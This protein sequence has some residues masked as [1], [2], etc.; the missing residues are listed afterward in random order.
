MTDTHM[1]SCVTNCPSGELSDATIDAAS[2]YIDGKCMAH[3]DSPPGLPC[4]KCDAIADQ[5][6]LPA[7]M[8]SDDTCFIGGYCVNAGLTRP[9]YHRYSSDS[10]CESCDPARN[11]ADWSITQGF[12][13]DQVFEKD[14][15]C[16]WTTASTG[17][18]RAHYA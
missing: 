2:C 7:T 13:K 1:A 18:S 3:G 14:H 10:V 12:F 17:H 9:A 5:R 4:F 11:A 6:K 15:D 16:R 8:A